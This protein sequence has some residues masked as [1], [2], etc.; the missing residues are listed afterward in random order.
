MFDIVS[1]IEIEISVDLPGFRASI[2]IHLWHCWISDK[3]PAKSDL[4]LRKKERR[5]EKSQKQQQQ[6]THTNNK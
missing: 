3:W 6:H 1:W 4:L 5:D 2:W